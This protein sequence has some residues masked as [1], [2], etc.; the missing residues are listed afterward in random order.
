MTGLYVLMITLYSTAMYVAPVIGGFKRH[1]SI[2]SALLG[3]ISGVLHFG[4]F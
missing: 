2:T 3:L 4:G 1:V